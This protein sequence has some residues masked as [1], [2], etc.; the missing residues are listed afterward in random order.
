MQEKFTS[1]RNINPEPE[2]DKIKKESEI[3]KIKKE[4][5]IDKIK[6][7]LRLI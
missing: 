7:N 5:E 3:Y 6:K 4:P 2:I 1:S